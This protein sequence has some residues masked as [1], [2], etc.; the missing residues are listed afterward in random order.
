MEKRNR[1]KN[2][3]LDDGS[4]DLR[5]DLERIKETVLNDY[6]YYDRRFDTV[7]MLFAGFGLY[8][9][10]EMLKWY[11]TTGYNL[12]LLLF[13]PILLWLS[14]LFFSL[15]NISREKKIRAFYLQQI[16]NGTELEGY[17]RN[18]MRDQNIILEDKLKISRILIFILSIIGVLLM[19]V[20]LGCFLLGPI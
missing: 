9:C 13:I 5:K 4:V 6:Q 1:M 11:L 20:S 16:I 18:E 10:F 12:S 3:M 2:S 8:G 17:K 15:Y 14:I 7:S 19:L